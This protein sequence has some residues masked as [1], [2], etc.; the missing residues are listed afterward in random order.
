M[1]VL[2]YKFWNYSRPNIMM[3]Y[4]ASAHC[5]SSFWNANTWLIFQVHVRCDFSG[6]VFSINP[7]RL[8]DGVRNPP[9]YYSVFYRHVRHLRQMHDCIFFF[10]YSDELRYLFTLFGSWPR[11]GPHTMVKGSILRFNPMPRKSVIQEKKKH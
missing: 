4:H 9:V 10:L 7:D 3:H 6:S 5:L 1:H 2:Q 11:A 8:G